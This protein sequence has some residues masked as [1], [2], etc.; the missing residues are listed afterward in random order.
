MGSSGLLLTILP[1]TSFIKLPMLYLSVSKKYQWKYIKNLKHLETIVN[2]KN[3]ITQE[4]KIKTCVKIFSV[5]QVTY[6][7]HLIQNCNYAEYWI[8]LKSLSFF[9][10]PTLFINIRGRRSQ[11]SLMGQMG[12]GGQ[13][14]YFR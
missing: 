14:P 13:R 10:S 1:K 2:G 9:L 11:S 12:P 7:V 8:N 4:G 3:S 5:M 6:I